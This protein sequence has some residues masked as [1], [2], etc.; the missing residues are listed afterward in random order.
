MKTYIQK[1]ISLVVVISCL[2]LGVFLFVN[3]DAMPQNTANLL[4]PGTLLADR[5]K[6]LGYV[7]NHITNKFPPMLRRTIEWGEVKKN[8]KNQYTIRYQC[9]AVTKNGVECLVYCWD[10]TFDEVGN[11][12]EFSKVSGFPKRPK[13]PF[14]KVAP[15]NTEKAVQSKSVQKE[16]APEVKVSAADFKDASIA[17]DKALKSVQN[18]KFADAE[19]QFKE[20][21][22]KNP[23][24]FMAL[25]GLANA[26]FEQN[27]NDDAKK[28]Y[29]KCIE[30]RPKDSRPLQAL[31]EIAQSEG[32]EEAML[33]WWKKSVEI[34]KQAYTALKGLGTYYAGKNDTKNAAMYFRLYLK[35]KNDTEI[36]KALEELK[37]K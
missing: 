15:S 11:F 34:D 36:S 24:N 16:D 4:A 2:V 6:M 30:M 10:F 37:N 18:K 12:V 9:E 19:I 28:T 7:E 29:L 23:N 17:Y 1:K 31:G 27:L 21:F 14:L 8:N 32:D 3:Q 33:D 13:N 5:A 22:S 26:Q 20:A 25:L 35:T